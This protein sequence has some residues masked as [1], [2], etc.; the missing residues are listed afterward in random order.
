MN[1][2]ELE[3]LFETFSRG[4]AGKKYW[5]QGS[6]L[7][8][9]IARRFMEMHGGKAWARSEGKG[10]GSTFYVELPL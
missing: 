5:V 1:E 2:E 6:G 8:L 4:G 7:G 9:Y 10:K 3:K